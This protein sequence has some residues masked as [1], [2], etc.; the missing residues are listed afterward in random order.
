MRRTMSQETLLARIEDCFD[1]AVDKWTGCDW[2][3]LFGRTGLNLDGLTSA[4]AILLARATAGREADDWHGAVAWLTGIEVDAGD[5]RARARLAVMLCREGRWQEALEQAH[6][7][8]RME[9]RY[10]R[11]TIWQP[12]CEAIEDSLHAG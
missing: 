11:V 9:G 8:N 10:H 5:A 7:A 3:T 2:P 12:L 6:E 1:Q 4:Q